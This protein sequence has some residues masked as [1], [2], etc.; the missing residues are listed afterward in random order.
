M[1]KNCIKKLK[2][3]ND[4]DI[5]TDVAQ[6]K[7]SNIKCYASVFSNILIDEIL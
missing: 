3:K 1:L 2:K 4:N 7:R 5:A 6:W